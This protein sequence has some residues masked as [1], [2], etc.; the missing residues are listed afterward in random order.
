MLLFAETALCGVALVVAAAINGIFPR[1][2]RA[3]RA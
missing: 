3:P 1:N 2:V